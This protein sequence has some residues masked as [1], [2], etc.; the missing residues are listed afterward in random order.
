VTQANHVQ[1][2]A[3]FL[4]RFS[5]EDVVH[6]I[7]LLVAEFSAGK[8]GI[9]IPEPVANLMKNWMDANGVPPDATEEQLGAALVATY[10][11]RPV[12]ADLRTGLYEL[13]LELGATGDAAF[14]QFQG[15]EAIRPLL[16][17]EPPPAN[18][19]PASPLARFTLQKKK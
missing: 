10:R 11:D 1:K 9:K 12:H 6:A 3:S 14:K 17:S 4:G 19:I 2:V 16:S 15:G 7:P 5:T 13:F 8:A 18:A